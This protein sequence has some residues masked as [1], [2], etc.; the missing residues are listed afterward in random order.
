MGA[1]ATPDGR[2][3]YASARTGPAGYNQ[4]LGT[5]QVVMYDRQTGRLERRTLN[6]GTGFRPQVS[7]DGKWLAYGSRRM[8]ITGLKLRELSSGDEQWLAND[9]QRDDIESR[10]SRDLL[11]GYAWMPD[12]K[13]LVLAH[14]GHIWR[15]DATSGQQ[16]QIPFTAEVDQMLGDLVRFEY[17][18]NDTT[19]TVRQIRGARPSPNGKRLVFSALDRLWIMDLPSGTPKRLTTADEG[20]HSPVWSPDGKY[21]A[22]VSWTEEGGDIWR[23]P[24]AGGK[25]EKLTRASAFYDEI[26]YSPTGARIVAV[27]APREQRAEIND[28]I[29]PKLIITD[30]VWIPAT[31]GR[32]DADHAAHERPAPALHATTRRAC[33]STTTRM[34]SCRCAG[35]APTARRTSS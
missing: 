32:G 34:A 11:P 17:P 15:V 10:G 4:M 33:G 24:A 31:G 29:N 19:L 23:V 6:L 5:T 13:A 16:T 26:A 28:E 7:P 27:R 1:S 21:I 9:I 12:S 3:I 8:A 20:E 35:T 14:H 2:Y 25:P 22:F 30:L 18:V